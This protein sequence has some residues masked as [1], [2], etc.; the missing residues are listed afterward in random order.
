MSF[1]QNCEVCFKQKKVT[2]NL[3]QF[4]SRKSGQ[5]QKEISK[6]TRISSHKL[7]G[8]FFTEGKHRCQIQFNLPKKPVGNLG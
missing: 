7:Q 8:P 2:N 1:L 5:T 3:Q 6:L 4:P